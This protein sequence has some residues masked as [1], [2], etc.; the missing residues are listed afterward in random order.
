MRGKVSKWI[1]VLHHL[2]QVAMECANELGCDGDIVRFVLPLGTTVNMNGTALYEATTVIFLAQVGASLCHSELSDKQA[3]QRTLGAMYNNLSWH[4]CWSLAAQAA[5]Q[6][7]GRYV[8]L[9]T[10]RLV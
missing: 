5:P 9:C 7:T 6:L 1:D 8:G 10:A 2:W 3:F 4:S